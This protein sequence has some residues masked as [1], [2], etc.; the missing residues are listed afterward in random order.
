MPGAQPLNPFRRRVEL[1]A[2]SLQ[3]NVV[4]LRGDLE[5]FSKHEIEGYTH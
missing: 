4:Q 5:A 2:V 3:S 1:K